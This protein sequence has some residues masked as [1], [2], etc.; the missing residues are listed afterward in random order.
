VRLRA[1]L[2]PLT[3]GWV[4]SAWIAFLQASLSSAFFFLRQ[5]VISSASGMK[6]LHSLNTSGVHAMRCS[7]V[8]S[9][10]GAGDAVAHSKANDIIDRAKGI[11]RSS[12]HLCWLSIFIKGLSM[13]IEADN[14]LHHGRYRTHRR[15]PAIVAKRQRL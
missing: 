8:P 12:V 1:P 4:I 3:L 15:E 10:E 6:A 9:E 13:V 7:G 11:G 5:V 2:P 14:R